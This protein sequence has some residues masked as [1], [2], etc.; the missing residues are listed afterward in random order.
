MPIDIKMVPGAAS[1]GRIV[2]WLGL[3]FILLLA[4]LIV[5]PITVIPAGNVG[6]K[7]FFGSVST[8]KLSPASTSCSRSPGW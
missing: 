2:K 7:D 3:G 5:N 1:G 8:D 4:F 6:V